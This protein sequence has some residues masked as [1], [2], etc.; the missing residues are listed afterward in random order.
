MNSNIHNH[1]R[2]AFLRRAAQ[3]SAAAGTPLAATLL[4]A[5]AARP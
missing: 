4:T 1:A 2:R 3:L 5:G